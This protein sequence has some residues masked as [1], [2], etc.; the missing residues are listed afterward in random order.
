MKKLSLI[1]A[2]ILISGL[3]SAAQLV[4]S[5]DESQC[6]LIKEADC[7]TAKREGLKACTE[8]HLESANRLQADSL[9]LGEV[10]EM[11]HRK[12]SL[13]GAKKVRLTQV[14]AYYYQCETA[15]EKANTPMSSPAMKG[16]APAA[17]SIEDRLVQLNSL[18][19]KGLITQE[20]YESK[21][22]EILNEL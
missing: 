21:R 9:L 5:I 8:K 1:L 6:K 3:A 7:T 13:T 12:P 11:E 17:K 10:K 16:I 2:A 22:T 15:Q 19:D 20:E 4:E 14:Q 18:K